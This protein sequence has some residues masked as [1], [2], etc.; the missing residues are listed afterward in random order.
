MPFL[1]KPYTPGTLLRK[2]RDLLDTTPAP[3]A[4]GRPG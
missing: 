3:A 4:A 2:V 1:D